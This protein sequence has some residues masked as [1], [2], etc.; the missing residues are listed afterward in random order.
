M[1]EHLFVLGRART[2]ANQADRVPAPMNL[3]SGVREADVKPILAQIARAYD[4]N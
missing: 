1:I 4:F 3:Q 2:G